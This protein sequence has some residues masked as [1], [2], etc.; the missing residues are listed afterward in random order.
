[1]AA[2]GTLT[3]TPAAGATGIATVTVRVRDTGGTAEGHGAIDTSDAQIFTIT[4]SSAAAT[5][6]TFNRTDVWMSTSSANRKFDLKAEV[7]KNG[8][9]VLT[10]ILTEQALG[11][12]TSFDKAINKT[13][14]AFAAT[15]VSFTASDTLSVRFSVKVSS[16]SQGGSNA[17]GAIR[18]WYN[19]PTPPGNTSHLHARRG[20]TDVK[21]YM[22]TPFRLQR[23]GTVP[24]PTQ[25]VPAVVYK[26]AY[27]ELGTWSITGP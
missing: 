18:L 23:D 4:V 24:G 13:I 2:N 21:Y 8:V 11:F 5:S 10:K 26:T 9:T 17:S 22:I 1:V 25:S 7:L 27:T 3:Y 20:A 19:I 15:P 12:G 16:S 6:I 14:G